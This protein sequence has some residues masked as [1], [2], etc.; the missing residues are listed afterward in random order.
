MK[1]VKKRGQLSK[2]TL[3]MDAGIIASVCNA[4]RQICETETV[5][6]QHLIPSFDNPENQK[7]SLFQIVF[8]STSEFEWAD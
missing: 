3:M 4:F 5:Q 1:I 8:F 2:I 7:I 6:L